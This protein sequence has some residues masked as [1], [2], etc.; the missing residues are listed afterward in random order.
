MKITLISLLSIAALVG[1]EESITLSSNPFETPIASTPYTGV[2]DYKLSFEL[3]TSFGTGGTG[4][5]ITLSSGWGLWSQMGN[6]VAF[7]TGTPGGSFSAF[8]NDYQS[9]TTFNDIT[10]SSNGWFMQTGETVTS[11]DTLSGYT[12]TITGNQKDATTVL[13][14]AKEG[15]STITVNMTEYL[16]AKDF[17]LGEN[18]VSAS[19]ITFTTVPEPA[20]ATLS[21]LAL[22][23]LAVRRRRKQA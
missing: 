3:T 7:D 17:V 21:L 4:T 10:T 12:L 11:Y 18:S 19:N 2:E 13:T 16:N 5:I 6:F 1:A 14:F 9:K 15:K 8:V 20:T 23:G 22:A